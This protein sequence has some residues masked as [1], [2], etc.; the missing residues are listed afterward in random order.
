MDSLTISAASGMRA[1]M[2]SLE[3]LANNIANQAT[4]GYK[5]DRES[6]NLYLASEAVELGAPEPALLPVIERNWTDFAQGTLTPT[7]NPLDVAI[8]GPGFFTVE[9]PGGVLYTRN[10]NFRLSP[11]GDLESSEGY[12]V[13]DPS[14]AP[15]TVDPTRPVQISESGVLTQDGVPVAELGLVSFGQAGSIEKHSGCYFRPTDR[16]V[17]PQQA[18]DSRIHQGKLEAANFSSA[19]AAVRLVE[20]MRQF[21]MLQRAVSLGSEMNQR[22]A[23]EVA[24]VGG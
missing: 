2:E 13:L 11:G 10:G 12:S 20:V 3:L 7:G 17:K 9:G 21:E 14:G 5:S 16:R 6:Y 18:A 1:R 22:A 4:A 24:R 19:E 15:V 8:S 23:E